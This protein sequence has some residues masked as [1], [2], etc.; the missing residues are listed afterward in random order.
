MVW[1]NDIAGFLEQ[2]YLKKKLMN[3]LEFWYDDIGSGNI[4]H[5]LYFFNLKSA[6]S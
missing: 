4:K 6:I 3:Q 1:G 5:G 2:I